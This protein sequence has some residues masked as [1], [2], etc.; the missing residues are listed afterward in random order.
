V[1]IREAVQRIG[2][3]GRAV[4]MM[5]KLDPVAVAL[6]TQDALLHVLAGLEELARP[7]R[8]IR[9]TAATQ[10]GNGHEGHGGSRLQPRSRPPRLPQPEPAAYGLRV[11][12][13][14]HRMY[15]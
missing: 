6:D 2:V 1:K 8:R 14:D 9:V 11:M 12:P 5:G 15:R 10:R 7:L 3:A 13:L 4:P